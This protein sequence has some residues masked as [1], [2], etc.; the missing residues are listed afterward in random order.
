[1][2][3]ST[4]QDLDNVRLALDDKV[5]HMSLVFYHP[6]LERQLFKEFEDYTSVL[7]DYLTSIGIETKKGYAF[8][9]IAMSYYVAGSGESSRYQ[10]YIPTYWAAIKVSYVSSPHLGFYI[11]TRLPADN[12]LLFTNLVTTRSIGTCQLVEAVRTIKALS[13]REQC[14]GCHYS[15]SSG[16]HYCGM[17][18]DMTSECVRGTPNG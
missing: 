6:E 8:D 4:Y 16:T 7:I 18:L 1:M 2:D 13:Q 15:D 14:R 17:G 5:R 3:Q 9:P 11:R 12:S 10:L